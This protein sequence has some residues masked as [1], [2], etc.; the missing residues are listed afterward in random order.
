M[1]WD[2]AMMDDDVATAGKM[3]CRPDMASPLTEAL[4]A[5]C[6]RQRSDISDAMVDRGADSSKQFSTRRARVLRYQL[7]L[8]QQEQGTMFPVPAWGAQRK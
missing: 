7:L 8:Y 6:E 3:V 1:V 2:G 4:P 5:T